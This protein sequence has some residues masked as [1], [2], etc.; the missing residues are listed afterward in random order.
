MIEE[1]DW[2]RASVHLETEVQRRRDVRLRGCRYPVVLR[3]S[4][5]LGY[6]GTVP[7]IRLY[8]QGRTLYN[9]LERLRT[10]INRYESAAVS[11]LV[12]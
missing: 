7:E 3:W 8:A 12:N 4:P 5:E 10:E 9:V 2:Y 6:V 11:S 1:H